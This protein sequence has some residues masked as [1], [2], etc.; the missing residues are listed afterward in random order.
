MM[1][2]LHLLGESF[3]FFLGKQNDKSEGA[4]RCTKSPR[5]N[6]KT[7]SLNAHWLLKDRYSRKKEG[8]I[9]DALSGSRRPSLPAGA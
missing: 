6:S 7:P 8:T 4:R 5:Q 2:V 9:P 3:G 1:L